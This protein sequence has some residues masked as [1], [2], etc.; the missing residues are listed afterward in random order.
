MKT[1]KL[2]SLKQLCS[3]YEVE[4]SFFNSLNE[5]GLIE[6]TTLEQAHYIHQEKIDAI[7]KMIRM[8][9]E[10]DINV[11]GIDT[12]FNLL[13]RM[14]ELQSELKTLKNRLRLYEENSGE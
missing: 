11:A 10:L 1:E 5:F 3:H 7:E 12:V 9:H 14:D 8:H 6:I 2:I 4:M 13:E